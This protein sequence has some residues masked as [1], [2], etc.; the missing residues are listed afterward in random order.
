MLIFQNIC[1]II[2]DSVFEWRTEMQKDYYMLINSKVLPPVYKNVIKA[3]ELLSAGEIS[4]TSDAVKAAGLSRSAFY[5]Y[6]DYVFRYEAENPHEVTLNAVLYD[7]AG[8]LA[9]MTGALSHFGANIL[10][11]NQSAPKGGAAEVMVKIRTDNMKITV[12][13]LIDKLKMVDGIVSVGEV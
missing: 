7:R 12:D 5:K 1:S 8:V 11:V 10:T 13:D 4:S 3:K 2:V 9:A 6:K